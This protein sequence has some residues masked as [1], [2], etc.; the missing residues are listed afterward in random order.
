LQN[1][2]KNLKEVKVG[3]GFRE[4]LNITSLN[5]ANIFLQTITY[6]SMLV[7]AGV[8]MAMTVLASLAVAT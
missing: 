3:N 8:E 5:L 1:K 4:L 7:R 2:N 6:L